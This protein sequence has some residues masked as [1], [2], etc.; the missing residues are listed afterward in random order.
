MLRTLIELAD[1][2]VLSSGGEGAAIL[3]TEL[4]QMV[5]NG[6]QLQLGS[7]CSAMLECKLLEATDVQ[8]ASGEQLT[9]YQLEGENKTLLGIFYPQTPVRK[10]SSTMTLTAFDAVSLLDRDLS[11]WLRSLDQWPYSLY[12][13]AD[14]VCDACGVRLANTGIPNGELLLQPFRVDAVTGRQLLSW[15]A[16]VAGRFVRATKAGEVER[17]WYPPLDRCIL[18]PTPGEDR[19]ECGDEGIS[20]SGDLVA[21]GDLEITAPWLTLTDDGAGNVTLTAE[22]GAPRVM[23]FAGGLQLADH[24]IAPVEKVQLRQT[25]EDVGTVFPDDPESRNTYAITANP[26]LP[27]LSG[28]S[29]LPVAQ[30]LHHQ[31]KQVSYTPCTIEMP[32]GTVIQPGHILTVRSADGRQ[33]QTWI[34]EKRRRGQK[35][36]LTCVGSPLRE[37][38]ADAN[39]R[40]FAA[41]TGKVLNLRTDVDGIKAENRDMAGKL[42]SVELDLDGLRTRTERLDTLEDTQQTLSTQLNQTADTVQ[43]LVERT[44]AGQAQQVKT[45]EGYTFSDEGLRIQRSGESVEN[46]LT[47]E[48]MY[49]KRSGSV[50]LQAD[51]DGVRAVDVTVGNFLVMGEHARFEDYPGS[52]TA[53]FYI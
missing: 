48:G 39:N 17:N 21:A 30:T 10:G 35:D 44:D 16:E 1:G 28:N 49:V 13:F 36:T 33:A 26:L 41:L 11:Q 14:M 29:L 50:I 5:N 31:L 22:P 38:S 40:D 25:E 23:Y 32:A 51:K 8:I 6:A 47:H 20:L 18:A 12:E 19:V 27:A 4:T 9:V 43:I 52:R 45:S 34:M 15:V 24:A 2:T 7:V 42:T 53:C 37:N 3:S 46:L